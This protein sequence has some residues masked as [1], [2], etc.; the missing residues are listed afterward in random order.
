MSNAPALTS[1]HSAPSNPPVIIDRINNIQQK[2][3]ALF[4]SGVTRLKLGETISQGLKAVKI[5]ENLV[6]GKIERV[7]EPDMPIRLK[8]AELGLNAY[9]DLNKMNVVSE[10]N[11]VN[12]TIGTIEIGMLERLA[13]VLEEM[14]RKLFLLPKEM[15]GDVIEVEGVVRGVGPT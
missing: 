15:R 14:N 10:G 2:E 12:I 7:E 5:K 3:Q 9:G 6:D 11:K 13:E 1:T 4:N 8:A